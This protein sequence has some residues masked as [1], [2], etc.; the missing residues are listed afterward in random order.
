MFIGHDRAEGIVSNQTVLVVVD[1]NRPVM[2]E[3]ES[4]LDMTKN[5][6]GPGPSPPEQR[7]DPECGAVLYR[8]LCLLHLRDGGGDPA[9]FHR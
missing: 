1:T 5:H 2:T 7:S 6:R 8:T 9:V 3:C 4:L